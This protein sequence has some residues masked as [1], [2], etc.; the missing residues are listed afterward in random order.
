MNLST[1]VKATLLAAM[2]LIVSILF[3]MCQLTS[4]NFASMCSRISCTLKR[5]E[6]I[7]AEL[8]A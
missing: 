3:P 6:T 4:I 8:A 5:L 1:K 7:A 2:F